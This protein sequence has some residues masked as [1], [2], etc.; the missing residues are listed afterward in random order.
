MGSILS[1]FWGETTV[2]QQPSQEMSGDLN[3]FLQNGATALK[4]KQAKYFHFVM[5]NEASDMDSMISSISYSFFLSKQFN[6]KEHVFFPVINIPREDFAL[7]TETDYIFQKLGVK[8]ENLQFYPEVQ[9]LLDQLK[10]SGSLHLILV[11]HNK[12]ATSQEKLGDIVEE[13]VDH[14]K[15]EG[16]YNVPTNKR[17]IEMVGSCCTL[18][19]EKIF[20]DSTWAQSVLTPVV[21]ELLLGTILLDTV[22]LDPKYKKVTP[23]D[24]DYAVRLA[25]KINF[26]SN[27]QKE[28]FDVLQEKR[29]DV[30]SLQTYDLLR[31]DYKQWQMGN[32]MVGIS[33]C[34]RSFAE[35]FQKDPNMT[36][37][38]ERVT[39]NM[40]LDI[41]FI[42]T[43]FMDNQNNM[44]REL[45]IYTKNKQ[46]H[47]GAVAFLKTTDLELQEIYPEK[48]AQLSQGV[49]I[50]FY[51]QKNVGAS[52]KQLQ[53]L[54]DSFYSKK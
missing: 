54:L 6:S 17:T 15:D 20:S 46:L 40:K 8:K 29:F 37:D 50:T 22:N 48:A 43:Q 7:R 4:N 53:P 2:P 47:D 38:C 9:P 42:M 5:G 16:L 10:S 44:C 52:R 39:I 49:I 27:K 11:D 36:K 45:G 12:L 32:V 41:H 24:T 3:T 34:K 13:I 18:V 28:L 21:A 51:K 31:A 1:Y 25:Q 30:S 14:H 33:S 35:W 19:A 23:K 26:E